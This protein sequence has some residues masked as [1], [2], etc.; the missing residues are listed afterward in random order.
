MISSYLPSLF[1][2]VY[3]YKTVNNQ[4]V[5]KTFLFITLFMSQIMSGFK[6]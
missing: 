2:E 4:N 6:S 3:N 1:Y 5:C